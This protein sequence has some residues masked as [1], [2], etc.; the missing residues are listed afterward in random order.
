MA[1]EEIFFGINIDT[2]DAIKDF[3][4]LKNRTKALKKE[5]DGTKVGTKR[6]E[7]LKTEITRNQATIRRFNRELRDTKSLATRVGQGVTNAFKGIAGAFAG[8]FAAQG[9]F[10]FFKNASE[11]IAGFEQ[12]LAKVRAV[13]GA[14]DDEFK[15]L[16]QSA[17]ELGSTSQFTA[18]QVGELQEEFAKLGF[19][20]QEILNATEATLDLA[21][22]TQSD[23][24]QAAVVAASTIRGFGLDAK[25]TQRVTDV[26]AAS[27][28]QSSLDINK[29]QTAMASVAPVAKSA[30]VSLEQTTAILGKITDSGVDAS[31][32]GTALR[33]I[34]LKLAETGMTWDEALSSI[35]TATDKNARALELFGTRG[36]T[37]ATIIANNTTNIEEFTA[38]LED[39][40]GAASDM[41][42]IVGDT[43]QGDLKALSSA[44]E[45]FILSFE[46]G[47]N[48]IRSGTQTLT[49]YISFINKTRKVTEDLDK[50]GFKGGIFFD[51]EAVAEGGKRV[52]ELGS[53]AEKTAQTLLGIRKFT[54]IRIKQLIEEG[55]KEQLIELAKGNAA[56]IKE[57]GET[58]QAV[59]DL[60]GENA[61][62]FVELYKGLAKEALKGVEEIKKAN[63]QAKVEAQQQ[64]NEEEEKRRVAE[65]QASKE[66]AKRL[67]EELRQELE[68]RRLRAEIRLDGVEE[69]IELIDIE[70]DARR[71]K[72]LEAGLTEQEILLAEEQAKEEIRQQYRDK[73]LAAEQKKQRELEKTRLAQGEFEEKQKE[74]AEQR[75]QAELAMNNARL[76]AMSS[77]VGSVI[78]LLSRDEAAR[79]KNAALIKALSISDV[80]I[81]TQRALANVTTN[82]SA[83]TPQNL[84]SNGIFG[85]SLQTVQKAAILVQSA[86][87]I[88]TIAA[89]KFQ[90]GGVLK[91][92]SHANGGIPIMAGGGMVE[93]EGG[94][95]I[96]NK[97]STAAFAPILSAINSYGGYGDKFERGGLLGVP[98][99]SPV[100]DTTNAQLLGALNN[101]NFQ[102]TVSVIEINEAQT[103]INEVNTSSQL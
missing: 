92:A 24:G 26:M 66:R 55:N 23:L 73:Q 12:Q 39:S 59:G 79:K 9:I 10:N 77:M 76:E 67:E 41:A 89:Q 27:F 16:T 60:T 11:T 34:Y 58:G 71:E 98:S 47:N 61:L 94:E 35:N 99:T 78:S 69:A 51:P 7:Q 37:V 93:A 52:T 49:N 100:G 74:K 101:I 90:R 2:G 18:S 83:P 43:L 40:T 32:A 97:K 20:T 42:D 25:E 96:I 5:L 46:E 1:R 13:T 44:W 81:N 50:L 75:F 30:G 102:P 85:L 48:V 88:A 80:I 53:D 17:K 86:G 6:F 72:L 63:T 87:S 57:I 38:A 56:T 54:N 8:A 82:T 64:R 19:S 62:A 68:Y 22:A 65:E 84:L 28:T 15:K 95:A 4:T 91:G 33:N 14:S 29:F 45:G 36:A 21:T 103:R 3:G 31:T 70:F